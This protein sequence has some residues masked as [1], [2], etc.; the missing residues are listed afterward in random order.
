MKKEEIPQDRS[1]LG[2]VNIREVYY[3]VDKDGK[4][5]TGLS[6][7]WEAKAIA[8]DLTIENLNRDI[9][10]ARQEVIN[11]NKSPLY[12]FMWREKMDEGILAS[13]V[14]KFKFIVKRHFKPKVFKKLSQKTLNKYAEVFEVDV[15]KL[16]N[17]NE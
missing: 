1:K 8:L 2:D 16:I 11:G 13:Y 10:E 6:T 5:T 12:Y 14:G 4:Y 7:G 9:E 3:V 15:E 17:F